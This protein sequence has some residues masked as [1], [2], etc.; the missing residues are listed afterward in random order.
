[1]WDR[2][3]WNGA[4]TEP[5]RDVIDRGFG[6]D[7]DAAQLFYKDDGTEGGG[8]QLSATS[9]VELLISK[10]PSAV[11][12]SRTFRVNVCRDLIGNTI[13]AD[14]LDYLH[15][16]WH[17]IGK[18]RTFDPRLLEYLEIRTREVA[19]QGD[20]PGGPEARV[21][22]NLRS[23]HRI[24]T[25]AVTAILDLL[26]S[27][28][29]L[30]EIALFHRTKVCAAAMLERAIA[31]LDYGYE[32]LGQEGDFLRDLEEALLDASDVEM[33][34]VL[35]KFGAEALKKG[36]GPAPTKATRDSI[37][38]VRRLT[39]ALRQRRLHEHLSST[40][41]YQLPQTA[42]VTQDLYAGPGEGDRRQ[43]ASE[44]A[45]NRLRAVR[46]LE[47]DFG[48]QRGS[49]VMYCPPRDM[50]SKIADVQVLIHSDVH[51]LAEF[52]R[53]EP[54]HGITGG[55]LAAQQER[56][57]RLWRIQFAIDRSERARLQRLHLL[58]PLGRAIDRCILGS[59]PTVGDLQADVV[60]LARELTKLT[61]TPLAGRDIRDDAQIVRV[62][63]R[64]G[65]R[66]RYPG[67]V[68][69]LTGY[70]VRRPKGS[71]S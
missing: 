42:K 54:D 3:H 35:D 43:A 47:D 2:T 17:H 26:E 44:G 37:A 62:A 57:R 50:N 27:R 32:L 51:S 7:A 19:A 60:A 67:G 64:Q 11:E 38:A 53:R 8:K 45:R 34:S 71:R 68:M 30:S 59:E 69:R 5:L 48:M 6:R 15:R 16:D 41:E 70:T 23:G 36:R 28:Y 61:E 46:L 22:I 66:G 31:E 39:S 25:D 29:Q 55:H 49:L 12:R 65:D 58:E 4:D 10:V 52:E 63:A 13:C 24:R 56:F 1:V 21:V 9:I 14:L 33:L 20:D 18:G 40:F